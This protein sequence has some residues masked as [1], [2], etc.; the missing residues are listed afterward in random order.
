MPGSSYVFRRA[1]T[2]CGG[3]TPD[4]CR[5]I[6]DT[7]CGIY[8]RLA[9][10]PCLV[11]GARLRGAAIVDTPAGVCRCS[12]AGTLDCRGFSCR[13]LGA[14]RRASLRDLRPRTFHC[15]HILLFCTLSYQVGQRF[16]FRTKRGW[17]LDRLDTVGRWLGTF[18]MQ[19]PPA[20]VGCVYRDGP[21][22]VDFGART[23]GLRISCGQPAD[24][25]GG[26]AFTAGR[27]LFERSTAHGR[28]GCL[29]DSGLVA[30]LCSCALGTPG[31]AGVGLDRLFLPLFTACIR[32]PPQ[33]LCDGSFPSP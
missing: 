22:E 10:R 4:A 21:F 3:I 17:A 11:G 2:R 23:G 7:G 15:R 18:G 27:G 16:H 8:R 29:V 25:T 28:S 5:R 30:A 14:L 13:G 9:R 6:H 24:V 1:R 20:A 12:F 26:P 31:S 19:L 33:P 32:R